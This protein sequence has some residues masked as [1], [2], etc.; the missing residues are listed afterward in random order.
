MFEYLIRY[1]SVL[2]EQSYRSPQ[3]IILNIEL[4]MLIILWAH[5]PISFKHMSFWYLLLKPHQ[6]TRHS[7]ISVLIREVTTKEKKKVVYL[8]AHVQNMRN[9]SNTNVTHFPAQ[10]WWVQVKETLHP[11]W[12]NQTSTPIKE[13]VVLT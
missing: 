2:I 8:R 1:Q 3:I 12:G 11:I 6:T 9:W 13:F 5:N 4:R 10:P 7:H